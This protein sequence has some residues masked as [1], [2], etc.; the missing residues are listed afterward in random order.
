MRRSTTAINFVFMK[1]RMLSDEELHHLEND[2]KA[3]LIIN[4]VEGDT[5]KQLNESEPEKAVQLVELFSDAVLQTVYEKIR[6][7]EFRSPDSCIVFHCKPEEVELIS[8]GRKPDATCDLSTP[9][10]IHEALIHHTQQLNWFRTTKAYNSE[11]ESEIHRML[12]Q[13]GVLSTEEFWDALNVA[14]K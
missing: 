1:Y 10:S 6:F 3:F 2:L 7:L 12:E 5:W 8:I 4:G 9:E 13:G 14:L 11:R